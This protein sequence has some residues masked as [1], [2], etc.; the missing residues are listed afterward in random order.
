MKKATIKEFTSKSIA[1]FGKKFNYSKVKY[2]NSSTPVKLICSVH[3]EIKY[4]NNKGL[5]PANVKI[6]LNVANYDNTLFFERFSTKNNPEIKTL[7]RAKHI[8]NDTNCF[9]WSEHFHKHGATFYNNRTFRLLV[10]VFGPLD[11]V[12][13][14]QL[15]NR[16]WRKY[17]D[18][19]ITF[20]MDCNDSY[21]WKK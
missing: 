18:Y 11:K 5:E 16:S 20:E 7:D 4:F 13:Y 9:G 8:P 12:K 19:A 17:K 2:I 10:N 21:T 3:G 14:K 6:L 1:K 15:I